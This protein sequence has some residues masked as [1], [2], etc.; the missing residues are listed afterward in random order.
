MRECVTTLDLL[1]HGEPVGGRRFRGAVDDPLSPL[2]WAQMRAAV[3]D[4]RPWQ[5]IVSSPLKRCAEFAAE[6]AERHG[7]PLELAPDLREISFGQWDGRSVAEIE[8]EQS[9]ALGRFWAD[10]IHHPPPGGESLAAFAARVQR[11][12][13]E[14]LARHAGRHLLLICHGGTIRALLCAVLDIPL[15]RLWRLDVPYA[16]LSRVRVYGTGEAASPLLLFHAGSLG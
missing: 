11:T 9:A 1:R 6:L 5:V 8:A 4:H 16:A 13:A 2:G 7:L 10:P 3:G 12:W 15:T 14:L